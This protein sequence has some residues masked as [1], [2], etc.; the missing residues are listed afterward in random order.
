MSVRSRIEAA[1]GSLIRQPDSQW[2]ISVWYIPGGYDYTNAKAV[3]GF[4]PNELYDVV[5]A[6]E[7]EWDCLK[8]QALWICVILRL[9]QLSREKKAPADTA[10]PKFGRQVSNGTATKKIGLSIAGSILKKALNSMKAD[11]TP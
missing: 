4:F 8:W 9:M 3:V 11:W 7:E 10:V 5:S 2:V 6:L 1:G